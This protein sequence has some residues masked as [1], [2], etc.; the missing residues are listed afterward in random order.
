VIPAPI[1]ELVVSYDPGPLADKVERRRR[2]MRS[3]LMSLGITIVIM[4]VIYVWQREQLQ[5]AGFITVY[6]VV[7]GISVGFVVFTLIGYL[8]ARRELGAIGTGTAIRIGAPG[9]QVAG[10]AAPWTQV[11]SLTTVKGG[12]GREPALRLTLSDGRTSTLPFDQVTVFPATLDTT[13]RAFSG[14]RHGIDLSALE[15]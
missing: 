6:A 14:G 3:R 1:D 7:L 9:I 5:G 8:R 4:I 11:T 13:V 15:T 10:L 12:L 2:L